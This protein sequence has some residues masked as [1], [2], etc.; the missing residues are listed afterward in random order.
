MELNVMIQGNDLRQQL[1]ELPKPSYLI[2]RD[3]RVYMADTSLGLLI[4][5]QYGTYLN[6]L[7]LIGLHKMQIVG[8]QIIYQKANQLIAYDFKKFVETQIP[9]PVLAQSAIVQ[10]AYCRNILYVLYTDRLVLYRLR[11]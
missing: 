6:T 7:S 8:S 1:S 9:I 11:K 2:E 4:F 3:R 5:D 10:A